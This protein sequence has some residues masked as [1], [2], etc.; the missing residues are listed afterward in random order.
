MAAEKS[1]K[2]SGLLI[3]KN[4]SVNILNID[5]KLKRMYEF[6]ALKIWF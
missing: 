3:T 4:I 6:L 2:S 5:L 1:A